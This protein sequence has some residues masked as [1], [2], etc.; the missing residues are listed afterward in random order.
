MVI[1]ATLLRVR[2]HETL[3]SQSVVPCRTDHNSDGEMLVAADYPDVYLFLSFDLVVA[4]PAT[5]VRR[6]LRDIRVPLLKK[7]G[8]QEL[9]LSTVISKFIVRTYPALADD[10][11][12]SL[13]KWIRDVYYDLERRGDAASELRSIR[14]EL[15]KSEFIKC[16]DGNYGAAG[17]LY[18][19]AAKVAIDVLGEAAR[20]PCTRTYADFEGSWA[21]F[22]HKCGVTVLP[23]PQDI[24]CRVKELSSSKPGLDRKKALLKVVK[25][26]A[27]EL[28]HYSKIALPSGELFFQA[29][30]SIEW[31]PAFSED[32]S[33]NNPVFTSPS[34]DLFR[35]KDIYSREMLALVGNVH[36][37]LAEQVDLK[38]RDALGVPRA[39][40]L[41]DVC[42]QMD[43]MSE[44]IRRQ[45]VAIKNIRAVSASFEASINTSVGT[46]RVFTPPAQISPKDLSKPRA[47][48]TRTGNS[49]WRN[50]SLRTTIR[51]SAVADCIFQQPIRLS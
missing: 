3:Q 51:V 22:F 34:R 21:D 43:K 15:S 20:T 33:T 45:G 36:P 11:R 44:R 24:L 26:L 38:L 27:G 49:G 17:K 10:K 13:L 18:M 1:K 48:S 16:S 6:G 9:T 40:A 32:K 25:C 28:D 37:V 23:R 42:K 7:L 4:F 19:P 39:P 47:S 41:D 46:L 30:K 5:L 50:M 14:E 8:I 35:P 2:T 29:L 12:L 31:L